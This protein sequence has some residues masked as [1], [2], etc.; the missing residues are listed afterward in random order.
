MKTQSAKPRFPANSGGSGHSTLHGRKLTITQV[1]WVAVY[2]VAVTLFVVGLP[3]L[4]DLYQ[5]LRIYPP[6]DRDAVHAYLIQLGLSVDLFAAY[7]LALSIIH[8]VAYFTV[9][10]VV[11]WRK[12]DEPMGLFVGLLL[13][14]Y[15]ATF[16][17]TT[18]VV[19]AI[20]PLLE[21]LNHFLESLA[22]GMLFLL[23]F[24]F[25][26]GRFVPR[27]T[28][29]PAGVL[30]TATVLSGL[31]PTSP[32]YI[33][34]WPFFAY[35]LFLSGWLLMGVYAQIYRYLRVSS[36]AQRQQT[37]WV[38]FGCTAA[39]A[40]FIGV[41]SIDTLLPLARPE[42][43]V[44][45]DLVENAVVFG[46]MLIIPIS[47]GVAILRFH[48]WEI[49]LV[50]NRTLVYGSLTA[51]LALVYLG[52]VAATEALFR[53]LTSQERQPQLAIV[54]ST[55][56]I[57][58]LFNPLRRSIQ[59]FIDRSFYR[60][61]YDARKT[62]EAFSTTLR[63]ATD[64]N[65]LTDDLVGVV[66]KTMQPAQVSVWLHPDPA[67]KDKRKKRAAIRESGHDEE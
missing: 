36:S 25:P 28:R 40:G 14:L 24:I 32:Y 29:W 9:A 35:A 5:E 47:F 2:L 61:K 63:D 18:Y 33:D 51:M 7:W 16:W 34:N 39:L 49:D 19:G 41:M 12:S 26:N 17:G 57:A 8:A 45:A 44:L 4:Y 15:G 43:R 56:V 60:R 46:L 38:L 22:L 50:I 53:T 6:V 27:W 48:L 30:F 3:L 59:S 66:K 1:V 11:F 65:A 42:S 13:V 54:V 55:L 10:A 52:G 64:L 31:F 67:L 37:K 23:F 58:A 20:H 62:L 21:L